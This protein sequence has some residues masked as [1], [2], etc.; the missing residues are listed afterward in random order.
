[1]ASGND[2][3]RLF[4]LETDRRIAESKVAGLEGADTVCAQQPS[5]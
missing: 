3:S 1:L 4:D 2:P 5:P